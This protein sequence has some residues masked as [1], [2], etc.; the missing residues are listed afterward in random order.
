MQRSISTTPTGNNWRRRNDAALL[1]LL[2]DVQIALGDQHVVGS[3]ASFMFRAVWPQGMLGKF[4]ADWIGVGNWTCSVQSANCQIKT[5]GGVVIFQG[6]AELTEV[7]VRFADH[8]VV[9]NRI[10]PAALRRLDRGTQIVAKAFQRV[11]VIALVQQAEMA[12]IVLRRN[13]TPS[14]AACLILVRR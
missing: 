4:G 1:K 6:L 10:D 11:A 7:I 14:R 8:R 12:V 5:T 2:V 13:R 9:A 3:R